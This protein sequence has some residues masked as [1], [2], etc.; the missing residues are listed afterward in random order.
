MILWLYYYYDLSKNELSQLSDP[1]AQTPDAGTVIMTVSTAC[2][3][4]LNGEKKNIGKIHTI[5]LSIIQNL[6]FQNVLLLVFL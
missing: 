1:E 2:K 6:K 4:I 3:V 5:L